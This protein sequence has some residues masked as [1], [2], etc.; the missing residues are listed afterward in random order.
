MNDDHAGRKSVLSKSHGSSVV[1][2]PGAVVIVNA[3]D[4]G[5]DVVTTDRSL[6]C[7]DRGVVS[8]VSA[9]VF[10]GD[11]DR[12]AHLAR[13]HGV[14]A[15]LHLN[16]TMPYSKPQ[17]PSRLMEQQ[18]KI[19]RFL[20]SHRFAPVLYHPGLA[21]SFEYVVR[22]QQEEYERLY[23]TPAN[24][25]DG[26][27][28]MHLCANIVFQN[29][30]PRGIIVRRNIFL[31]PG[32][33]SWSNR[34]YRR[35]Q[36]RLLSHRYRLA[37]FFFDLL[38]LD[39]CSRMER[40]F[41]LGTRFNVEVETHPINNDEYKFLVDGELM[42]CAGKL[43]VARGYLLRSSDCGARVEKDCM[44]LS[45]IGEKS[46]KIAS[47]VDAINPA[48]EQH[49]KHISVCICTY[50]R[51]LPLKRLLLELSRQKTEGL[52]TYS[53]VVADNDEAR[54]AEATI[55][56]YR[57]TSAVPVKY[58][59]EPRRSIALARNK[60]VTSAEGE[61]SAFIDDDEF[62][63]PEWLLTLFKA[64]KYYEVDGVLGPVLRSFDEVPPAWLKKGQFYIRRV[65][66]TGMRVNWREARTG[67][68]L[69]NRR[70][71]AGDA[72]P[73]RPEFR[74]GEDQE[75]FK[76]KI[77]EGCAFVWCA[78]AE[79]YEVVPPA[80]WK[81]NYLVRRALLGG[82][83]DTRLS[84]FGI[85]NVVK[86]AIAVPL[87]GLLLPFTLLFGQH[88]FM[89]LLVSLCYHLGRLFALLGID[90]VREEYVTD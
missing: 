81:R 41:Q 60:V 18:E 25:I 84:T 36:D 28:H 33:K 77:E 48:P 4:W 27:H 9:M 21:A 66:T 61:Y 8:S 40:I 65:N 37:D 14:D 5:R 57:L 38:P 19:S 12:A 23:G 50:K 26:H 75:F 89:G 73:F 62:P 55:E 54:S 29:L 10:M 45:G 52:F 87:Y 86:A 30:L 13:Q 71:I 76:R 2:Q 59:V 68:V 56:E 44:S 7:I 74:V 39:P 64:Y 80:R 3:D 1:E 17:C 67:N 53:I 24:R 32:E 15:G 72:S 46:E 34:A 35:W 51:P 63:T 90:L 11:S 16:L 69:I 88:R 42:R 47:R 58:V 79:V 20:R 6:D 22:A 49:N 83:M 70:I 82:A 78:E 31:W 43:E 85:R